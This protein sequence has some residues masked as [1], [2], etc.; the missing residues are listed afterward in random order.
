MYQSGLLCYVQNGGCIQV[1]EVK[2]LLI[3]TWPV[4]ER[5]KSM[6]LIYGLTMLKLLNNVCFSL[7]DMCLF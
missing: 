1:C 6:S 2:V 5:L 4:N 7:P 3:W